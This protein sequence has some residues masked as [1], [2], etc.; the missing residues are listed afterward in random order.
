MMLCR[1]Q[2]LCNFECDQYFEE[3]REVCYIPFFLFFG[4]VV[5]KKIA[6][7]CKTLIIAQ[8]KCILPRELYCG[9]VEGIPFV[10]AILM[11]GAVDPSALY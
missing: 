10:E 7:I 6:E 1:K 5:R 2:N 3:A 4:E 11:G 9:M 8:N